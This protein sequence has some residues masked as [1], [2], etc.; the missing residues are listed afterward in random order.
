LRRGY[1]AVALVGAQKGVHE[2]HVRR[3][4]Q[5]PQAAVEAVYGDVVVQ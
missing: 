1:D 2:E 5:L 4:V 3:L